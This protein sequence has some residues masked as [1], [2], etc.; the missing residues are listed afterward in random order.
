MGV[1][2]F[3]SVGI[4]VNG[5]NSWIAG[6]EPLVNI[7]V[8]CDDSRKLPRTIALETIVAGNDTLPDPTRDIRLAP[9][10]FWHI[11]MNVVNHFSFA[12]PAKRQANWDQFG[13]VKLVNVGLFLKGAPIDLPGS[14]KHS[15]QSPR[16][17]GHGFDGHAIYNRVTVCRHDEAD[18]WT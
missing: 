6:A 8:R 3:A 17:F 10:L 13:I 2:E 11:F 16:S 14:A 7:F 12:E 1:V 9:H 18:L 5:H 4:V 15:F